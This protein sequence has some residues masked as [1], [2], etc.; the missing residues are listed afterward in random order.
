MQGGADDL[1]GADVEG[2][3]VEIA[4]DDVAVHFAFRQSAGTMRAG[5]VDDVVAIADFE[6]RDGKVSGGDLQAVAF[7]HI[8]RRASATVSHVRQGADTTVAQRD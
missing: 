1:A 4:L 7:G 8:G 5:I 3:V 2:A 6:D